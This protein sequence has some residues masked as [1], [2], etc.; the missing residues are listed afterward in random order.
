MVTEQGKWRITRGNVS[1]GNVSA[2][3][4]HVS[5]HEVREGW[6]NAQHPW[7]RLYWARRHWQVQSESI[8]H[9]AKHAADALGMKEGTY[10]AYE[11]PDTLSK[12]TKLNDQAAIKFAR[13]FKV[14]WQWLL[15]GSG[16]PF[17]DELPE[18][19]ERVLRVMSGMDEARQKALADIIE[20]LAGDPIDPSRTIK[21]AV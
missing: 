13:K 9:T 15:L 21:K 1:P 20:N 14:S 2:M 12:H 16:T 11:R 5:Q 6:R 17:D 4:K 19:Q 7:E 10:R 18:P 8:T 3:P